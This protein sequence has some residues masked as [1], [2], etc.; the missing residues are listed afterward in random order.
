MTQRTI[1]DLSINWVFD[2]NLDANILIKIQVANPEISHLKIVKNIYR[3][4]I[5]DWHFPIETSDVTLLSDLIY[6]I[7]GTIFNL[8]ESKRLPKFLILDRFE[9]LSENTFRI[10]VKE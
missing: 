5:N 10:H 7:D 4:Y 9:L 6:L 8:Q 2:W 3:F 1:A